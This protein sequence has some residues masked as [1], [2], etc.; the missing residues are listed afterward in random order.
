MLMARLP[1]VSRDDIPDNLKYVWDR[2]GTDGVVPNIFRTM[3]H[4][5]HVLRAYLRMGN[6]LWAHCGLDVKTRELA[7]LRTAILHHSDKRRAQQ[8]TAHHG[9]GWREA[10]GA[11]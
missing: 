10:W 1:Q 8:P 6:G 5:P 11:A 3:G 2:I 4:N 7:I 9:G